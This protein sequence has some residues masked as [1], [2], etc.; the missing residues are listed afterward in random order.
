MHTSLAA[1][2]DAGAPSTPTATP[3]PT[4]LVGRALRFLQKRRV[5]VSFALIVTVVL[6]DWLFVH[7]Q[8]RD[9]LQFTDPWVL[10]GLTLLVCGLAIRSW[11]AGTLHKT[12]QHYKHDLLTTTGPY[13]IVRNPLYLGS[14]LMMG[15]FCLLVTNPQSM[16]L[17]IVPVLGLHWLCVRK[18]ERLMASV[19]P[20]QWP[21]YRARVPAFIPRR[22]RFTSENWSLATWRANAEYQAVLGSLLILAGLIAWRTWF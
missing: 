12:G 5:A 3:Q 17:V 22:F 21:E 9:L 10:A 7:T 13:S 16:I 4:T 18:E 6:L 14:F 19:F 8:P 1:G 2:L 11:A 15:A 20:D